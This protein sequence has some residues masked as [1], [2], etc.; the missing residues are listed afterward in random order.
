MPRKKLILMLITAVL[1][2]AVTS[3]AFTLY[4]PN[5]F[6]TDTPVGALAVAGR[7]DECSDQF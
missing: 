6:V 3:A 1:V 5:W 2:A 4:L 7:G